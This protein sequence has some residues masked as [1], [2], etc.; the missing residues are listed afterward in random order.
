MGAIDEIW[1][2]AF[3]NTIPKDP[4]YS[5]RL[6]QG[7]E[8]GLLIHLDSPRN[9]VTLDFGIVQAVNILDEG[10]ILNVT[11]PSIQFLRQTGFSSVLYQ[12]ENSAYESYIQACM[13][14]ELYQALNL[15][16]YNVVTMNYV[17]EIIAS[18]EP[19]ITVHT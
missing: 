11:S 7:E 14:R 16:Q 9:Q 3:H 10:I 17:V 18:E 5:I 15:R 19:R 13:P 8:C 6:E 4:H 2:D 1:H 12:I